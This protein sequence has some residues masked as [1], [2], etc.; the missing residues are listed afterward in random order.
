VIVGLYGNGQ[1][2]FGLAARQGFLIEE[3][4]ESSKAKFVEHEILNSKPITEFVGFENDEVSFSMSFIAGHTTAPMVAIPLLKDLLSRAQ[5][6]PLIVGGRPVGSFLSQ[7]VLTEVTST[8]QYLNG[9]GLLMSA[10]IEVSMKEY[11]SLIRT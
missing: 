3:L 11:R 5:A 8:Y 9:A 7:F 1:I 2:V 4:E 10:S 6:Y